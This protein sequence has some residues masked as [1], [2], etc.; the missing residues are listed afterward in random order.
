LD[1]PA[2]HHAREQSALVQAI[3]PVLSQAERRRIRVGVETTWPADLKRAASEAA[4]PVLTVCYDPGNALAAG[5]DPVAEIRLLGPSLGQLRLR[6]RRRREI[7]RSLPLEHGDVDWAGVLSQL[8]EVKQLPLAVVAATGGAP[9]QE[10]YATA[11]R[12]L[13]PWFAQPALEQVA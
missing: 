6:D 4:G 13:A 5:R 9:I 12:L 1:A 3:A 11:Q 10:S 7:L 8:N 2:P